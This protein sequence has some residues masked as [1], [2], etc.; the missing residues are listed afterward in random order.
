M[1]IILSKCG[2]VWAL[3][4]SSAAVDR[5]SCGS[6]PPP[7]P[8]PDEDGGVEYDAAG[9]D[10]DDDEATMEAE[11]EVAAAL[12]EAVDAAAERTMLDDEASLPIEELMRRYQQRA[13]EQ[14]V[15]VPGDEP[16]AVR[17]SKCCES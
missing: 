8:P 11:E 4:G 9:V 14:G 15:A 3:Q 1:R 7:P 13:A 10:S 2:L 16:A 12:G 6:M 5:S 17:R